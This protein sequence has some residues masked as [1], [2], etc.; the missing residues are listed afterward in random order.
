[1]KTEIDTLKKENTELIEKNKILSN[2]KEKLKEEIHRLSL[3]KKRKRLKE[4][5]K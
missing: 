4:E 3:N 2:E 5:K 1:M